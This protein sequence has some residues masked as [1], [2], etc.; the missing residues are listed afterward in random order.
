MKRDGRLNLWMIDA[1]G[2]AAVATCLF[3]VIGML[4][5]GGRQGRSTSREWSRAI[6]QSQQNLA[7]LKAACETQRRQ[8]EEKQREWTK[9]GGL[10]PEAQQ[11]AYFQRL[12]QAAGRLGLKVLRQ[13][14]LAARQYPGILE[15][16][17]AYDVTG[18]TA[19]VLAFL[20]EIESLDAWADVSFFRIEQGL[21]ATPNGTK[22]RLARLTVS[23]FASRP[24]EPAAASKGA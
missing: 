1:A 19:A 24:L 6:Q 13:Q 17:F 20:R 11:E 22:E 10:P 18:S 15:R 12:S 4:A 23:L 3:A 14:P 8:L 5:V 2:A 16:R 21:D 7:A 9:G